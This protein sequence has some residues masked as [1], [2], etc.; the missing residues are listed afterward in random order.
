MVASSTSALLF[1]TLAVKTTRAELRECV[2]V[3]MGQLH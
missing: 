1:A 2:G 3:E